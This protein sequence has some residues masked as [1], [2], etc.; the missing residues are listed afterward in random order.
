MKIIAYTLNADGTIPEY[1]VDGGY[2]ATANENLSP[3]D[4]DLIGLATDNAPQEGF[5]SKEELLT[6]AQN[7][8]ITDYT[9]PLTGEVL[10]LSD[11]I[12]GIWSKL[13]NN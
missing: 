12:D 6:Y 9:N 3:Q 2:L 5:A 10:L 8:G 7:K 4:L 11:T 1:V 13:D